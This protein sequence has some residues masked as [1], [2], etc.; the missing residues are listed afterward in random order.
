MKSAHT[1][2]KS[3][4]VTGGGMEEVPTDCLAPWVTKK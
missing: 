3:N 4:N 1:E 2:V